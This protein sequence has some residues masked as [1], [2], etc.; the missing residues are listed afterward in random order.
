MTTPPSDTSLSG[1]FARSADGSD[2]NTTTDTAKVLDEHTMLLGMGDG[3]DLE[4]AGLMAKNNAADKAAIATEEKK[5]NKRT[6]DRALLN[7]ITQTLNGIEAEMHGLEEKIANSRQI[8]ADNNT[9]IEFIRSLDT[10][11]LYDASGNLRTDVTAFLK[12]RGYNDLDGKSEDDLRHMITAIEVRIIDQNEN[13]HHNIDGWLDR[14]GQLR[15]QSH[16]AVKDGASEKQRHHADELAKRD[17]EYQ[18]RLRME[19]MAENKNDIADFAKDNEAVVETQI[20]STQFNP[21]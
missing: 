14:H 20:M 4:S 15:Q 16:D 1:G 7:S 21:S 17:P 3:A 11:S 5:R 8:I 19:A 9:D 18:A 13:E 2:L 12:K 6:V 10:D